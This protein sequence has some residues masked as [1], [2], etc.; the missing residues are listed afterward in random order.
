MILLLDELVHEMP[1]L[2]EEGCEIPILDEE[3]W[4]ILLLE[5]DWETL[6]LDSVV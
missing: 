1:F 6:P 4:E 2:E 3:G 5:G